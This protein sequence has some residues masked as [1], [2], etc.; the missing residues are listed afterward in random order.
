MSGGSTSMVL[1]LSPLLPAP[2]FIKIGNTQVTKPSTSKVK[3][4]GNKK[5]TLLIWITINTIYFE[6]GNTFLEFHSAL[7]N[8][9]TD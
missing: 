9:A 3:G 4:V 8:S 5:R 6:D 7:D 1:S 2:K